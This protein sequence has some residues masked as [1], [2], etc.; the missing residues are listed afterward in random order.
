MPI[1]FAKSIFSTSAAA[2][3][4]PT[5][6][7]YWYPQGSIS[8]DTMAIV[9][10]G[11]ATS[12]T[13]PFSSLQSCTVACWLRGFASE[14]ADANNASIMRYGWSATLEG[15]NM[16]WGGTAHN[17]LILQF[18][19]GAAVTYASGAAFAGI[20]QGSWYHICIVLDGTN[21][22][23]TKV[24]VNGVSQTVS[25][26]TGTSKNVS[27]VEIVSL[28]DITRDTTS[29]ET[30]QQEYWDMAQFVFYDSVVDDISKFYSSGFVNLGTD[31]TATGLSQ[32]PIYI[33]VDE[34]GVLQQ[35]GSNGAS[36][37]TSTK[38]GASLGIVASTGS[39]DLSTAGTRSARSV[40]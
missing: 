4:G 8:G 3:A 26:F 9:Q 21:T 19:N 40:A 18:K 14:C 20:T 39:T 6:D 16:T 24:Y 31:G 32:P 36:V 30:I 37:F 10:W 15:I 22:A 38:G 35:G 17:D 23:N 7:G 5:M 2:A 1:G 28:Q 12:T 11:D 13:A 25:A 29:L 27:N 33:Y 34:S